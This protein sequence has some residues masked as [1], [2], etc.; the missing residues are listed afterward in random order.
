MMRR[1]LTPHARARTVGR[2]L[3][4]LLAAGAM[5]GVAAPDDGKRNAILFIGDGMG[6]STVTAARIFAGQQRGGTGEEHV[7]SFERFPNVALVKTY[8]TDMQVPD[9]AGTMSAIVTGVKT[10]SG[11]LSVAP[12]L[13]RGD[14]PGTAAAAL[15]TLLEEAEAAGL[16]TGLVSTTRITH[17]TPAAAYAHAA[18][19]NWEAD[20]Q[21]PKEHRVHCKDIAL[22][23]VEFEHGDGVDVVLGGG[24]GMFLPETQDDPEEAEE[25]G[26]R[27][28]GRDLVQEWLAARPGRQYA[29]N[30][31]QFRAAGAQGQLLGL[32]SHSHMQFE[33][34][35]AGDAGG[36]PSLAEMTQAAIERL[37]PAPRG[38]LLIVE[39]GRID[40]AHH[41][42]NAYR[43]LLDT[44]A[45]ADA[46]QVA[47][48]ATDPGD[49]LVM[50]TADHSHTLTIS[51]YPQRG[52]PILGY[53]AAD[54]ERHT[55]ALGRP[56]TTL[57][58][59]NGP[60]FRE[61]GALSGLWSF[62]TGFIGFDGGNDDNPQAP[63]YQQAAAW[64][65]LSETH[66][67][68]D[69]AA[70]AIG[71]GAQAVRG[72][73]EQNALHGVLRSALL[74]ADGEPTPAEGHSA[75]EGAAGDDGDGAR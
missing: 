7:L 48:E 70:Y 42:G 40:H 8:T 39:G 59:A 22:Q 12:S 10:R 71:P 50:V 63:D 2:R 25:R 15:P 36:E 64:P 9:S 75:D 37:A 30:D 66:G 46:V 62:V 4:W 67:G 65:L 54:G 38:Y 58:Y 47:V 6:V 14:C 28:D 21:V 33:A 53:A 68:E 5:T 73:M 16:R 72:V 44:V 69:V 55:D 34:D 41:F 11:V 27:Q 45:L 56:Y 31:E 13:Q 49:T 35:R 24:R 1:G 23:L 17:A 52:N 57:S 29:W 26:E 43:S 74:P 19:R 32:F 60:G 51:G 20:A 18:D 61:Q 3:A